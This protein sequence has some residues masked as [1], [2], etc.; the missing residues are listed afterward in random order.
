MVVGEG[1]VC[2]G[3]RAYKRVKREPTS[4]HFVSVSLVKWVSAI[5]ESG[6]I[7]VRIGFGRKRVSFGV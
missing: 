7:V 5:E 6:T 4:V 1:V 2:V 3:A